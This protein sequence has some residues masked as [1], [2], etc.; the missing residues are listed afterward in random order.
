MCFACNE[1]QQQDYVEVTVCANTYQISLERVADTVNR[2]KVETFTEGT[3]LTASAW[4]LNYPVY[5]FEVGDVTGD[6]MPE[7]AV[8]VIKTTRYDQHPAKRLFLFRITADGDVRPLWLGSRVAQPLEDFVLTGNSTPEKILTIEKERS[9]KYLVAVYRYHGFGLEFCEY[10]KRE[11]S[12]R[13]AYKIVRSRN[14]S[15]N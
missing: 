6:S 1:R 10:G 4:Q 13:E 12:K 11:I 7:I 5:R 14:Q 9:G 3:L 8:G 15:R 2:I